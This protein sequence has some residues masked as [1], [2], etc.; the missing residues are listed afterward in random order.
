MSDSSRPSST[1]IPRDI[2]AQEAEIE[3]IFRNLIRLGDSSCLDQTQHLP[4]HKPTEEALGRIL[5]AMLGLA[6]VV[7]FVILWLKV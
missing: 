3:S 7:A 2:R 4:N 1:E 5:I 6:G